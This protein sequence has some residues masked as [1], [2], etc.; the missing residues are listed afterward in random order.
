MEPM[1]TPCS[2]RICSRAAAVLLLAAVPGGLVALGAQPRARILVAYHS[3]TGNTEKLAQ[4][5][6][7]GAALVPGVEVTLRK[8]TEA[9]PGDIAHA[10]GILVGT[11]VHWH[12]LSAEAKRFL[13]RIAE[14]LESSGAKDWG[15]GRTGGAFCTSGGGSGGCE[16]ARTSIVD[17]L[18]AMRFVVIGGVTGEGFGTLGPAA[19]GGVREADRADARRFGERFARLT[20]RFKA[21]PGVPSR[22]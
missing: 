14:A 11:P 18:L 12:N 1:P 10:D 3:I 19:N 8:V 16:T 6:S 7:E 15:E 2:R 20:V 4:A 5:V 9:S 22:R 21:G 13:D 17:A